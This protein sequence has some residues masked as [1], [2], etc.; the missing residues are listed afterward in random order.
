MTTEEAIDGY[1]DKPGKPRMAGAPRNQRRQE[2]SLSRG[3]TVRRHLLV[4]RTARVN[5]TC[6]KPPNRSVVLSMATPGNSRRDP[7]DE[8]HSWDKSILRDGFCVVR[9]AMHDP[10]S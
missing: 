9:G 10:G 6:F 3:S 1:S 8:G 2:G 7:Y 4:S 5:F